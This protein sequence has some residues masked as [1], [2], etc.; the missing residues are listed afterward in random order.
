M[1]PFGVQSGMTRSPPAMP[2]FR[3]V[4]RMWD[5]R[6]DSWIARVLPGEYYVTRNDE[7][8]ST[9]LGSCIAACI[10]D[11]ILRVG[12]LNHFMLPEEASE[13]AA[14]G[15]DRWLDPLLGLATRYGSH[16]MER[17]INALLKCGARRERLEV[18]L[19][20]AGQILG[21]DTEVGKRN[22]AFVY[23]Y[24][25]TEKLVCAAED[26]G[27][28]YPRRI[29]YFPTSGRVRVKRLRSPHAETIADRENRYLGQIAQSGSDG[30]VEL[31]E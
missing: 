29:V 18:K 25:R 23:A 2:G 4:Q 28:I 3:S 17:L 8:I 10:R 9:V 21:T 24:L 5:S 6:A 20:G 13:R 26:L 16:A 14:G 30:D 19:F 27:D 31:F 22:I 12:G 1:S 15:H 11:P 7:L